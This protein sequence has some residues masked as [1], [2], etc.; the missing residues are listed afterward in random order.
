[1]KKYRCLCGMNFKKENDADSHLELFDSGAHFIF[2]RRL[3]PYLMELF[4]KF[5]L[6]I[7]SYQA[8]IFLIYVVLIH[9]FSSLFN[10]Y[11]SILL[12]FGMGL[13][14]AKGN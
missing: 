3:K 10:I 8:G 9:H 5:L 12:G 13:V 1:M 14:I 6:M 7:F 11:E 2:K 4:S